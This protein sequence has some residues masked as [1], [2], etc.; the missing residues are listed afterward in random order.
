V[1]QL[2]LMFF[3]EARENLDA[4]EQGLLRFNPLTSDNEQLDAIFRAAHSVKGGAAAF[5]FTHVAEFVHLTESLLQRLRAREL[6][7]DALLID[8]LLES[9]DA[10]RALMAWHQGGAVGS[11]QTPDVLVQRLRAV[12]LDAPPS[13][14][15]RSLTIRIGPAAR[16]ED[17]QA[18]AALFRDIPRLGAASELPVDG[19]NMHSFAV[20][21]DASDEELMALLSFHVDA[22]LVSI[23]STESM[24]F[25]G[26]AVLHFVPAVS[27]MEYSVPATPSVN[28][29]FSAY[30][31]LTTIRVAIDKV[32]HM[33]RLAGEIAGA[34]AL[35]EQ[36]SHAL[37]P[38]I[39]AQLLAGLTQLRCSSDNL[40]ESVLALRMMPMAMVFNRFPRILRDL[41][42]KLGKKFTL[43][44][45]GEDTELDK[46][47][48]E[49]I[50]DP[51]L[52]LVR[53]SCDHG[54]ETPTERRAAGKPDAGTITLG[55]TSQQGS[56]TIEVRDDGRGLA[57]EKILKAARERGLPVSDHTGN[58]ELWQL[59]F[60]A[61]FSTAEAVTEVSGRG[62]GLDVVKRTATA[63]GGE[64]AIAS[65]AGKG[66]SVTM[67][68]PVGG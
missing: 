14:A 65:T 67:R 36:G 1:S 66:T 46:T 3:D 41:S 39:H 30:A 6:R 24:P 44:V 53:N 13:P 23:Q 5:G 62:V 34:Q 54:I 16:T 33:A 43:I 31:E 60:A 56:V 15:A 2:H 57:R 63:L 8:L 40:R 47:V 48:V 21:T 42:R 59:V 18:V 26:S 27:G 38:L 51:L 10:T 17:L 61:G 19:E 68:L 28:S 58:S 11:V 29:T 37:D 35:L 9:V 49:R 45:Q 64:V 20:L 52:H 32:E 22:D 4:M 50:T 55:V 7:P 12:L 25:A